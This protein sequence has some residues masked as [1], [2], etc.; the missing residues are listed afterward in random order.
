MCFFGDNAKNMVH[1]F[2]FNFGGL[3]TNIQ[4]IFDHLFK[5]DFNDG[6]KSLDFSKVM[7]KYRRTKSHERYVV[8]CPSKRHPNIITPVD[9]ALMICRIG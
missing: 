5:G 7:K 8:F 3:Y 4:L 6:R 9:K 1:F 2:L